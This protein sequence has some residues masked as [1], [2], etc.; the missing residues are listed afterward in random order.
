VKRLLN[1]AGSALVLVW[2]L[3]P[4]TDFV[5]PDW[6]AVVSDTE[7]DPIEGASITVS[8]QQY[9]LEWVDH[10]EAKITGTD[11]RVHFDERRIRTQL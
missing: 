10:E 1:F 6:V 11:G 2:L 7:G 5:S 4:A 8:S 3:Y 9:T